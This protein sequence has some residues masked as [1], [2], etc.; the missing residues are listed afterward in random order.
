MTL[1][2]CCALCNGR[3]A[4]ITRPY[5]RGV[6]DRDPALQA[7]S[8]ECPPMDKGVE[9]ETWNVL[10]RDGLHLEV[11]NVHGKALVSYEW[12]PRVPHVTPKYFVLLN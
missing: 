11:S 8:L 4:S 3:E 2:R 12:P 1:S 5:R 10:S 6:K 9:W 7:R